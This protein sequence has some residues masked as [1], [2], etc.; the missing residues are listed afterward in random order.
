MKDRPS[1]GVGYETQKAA[2]LGMRLLIIAPAIG[3]ARQ[4]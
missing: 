2:S 4:P 3:D 1:W